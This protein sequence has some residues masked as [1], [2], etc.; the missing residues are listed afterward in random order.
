MSR[1]LICRTDAIGDLILTLPI[2]R[3]I[4]E[5][6]PDVHLT[7]LVSEYT[8]ELLSNEEYIDDVMTISGRSIDAVY[9]FKCLT[10]KLMERSFD[11]ALLVYP[12]FSL[13]LASTLA[14]IPLRVGT[15]YRSYSI[16]F[17]KAVPLHRRDSGKHELDLNYELAEAVFEDLPR[18]EPHLSVVDKQ[19][20]AARK[21]LTG[22][23]I[24]ADDR[25]VIIHSLS[26]GSA[27]NWQI[28]RYLDLADILTGSGLRVVLTGSDGEREAIAS[29]LQRRSANYLNLAGETDLPTFLGLIRLAEMVITGSTGPIHLATAIGTHA[30]GIYPPQQALSATRW[31][32]RGGA[33]KLFMPDVEPNDSSLQECMNRVPVA[34]VAAY[35]LSKC[36]SG[37][38]L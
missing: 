36:Q 6:Y 5:K 9:T 22:H 10:E 2:V 21:V 14:G 20:D 23:G 26:R 8:R 1:V 33:N 18:L 15:A 13:A 17:T 11:I 4:K 25:F 37:D 3:S 31:G 28:D 12:R 27:P 29:A 7:M 30:V 24:S 32:P 38:K 16:L 19:V 34:D 35:V